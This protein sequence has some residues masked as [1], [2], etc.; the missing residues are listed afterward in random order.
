MYIIY[1]Y[2]SALTSHRYLTRAP[3]AW[4]RS[5]IGTEGFIITS[6]FNGFVGGFTYHSSIYPPLPVVWFWVHQ[7]ALTCKLALFAYD[8]AVSMYIHCLYIRTYDSIRISYTIGCIDVCGVWYNRPYDTMP[9]PLDSIFYQIRG[10]S[11]PYCCWGSVLCVYKPKPK[12]K[13][14]CC[15]YL[16]VCTRTASIAE[17]LEGGDVNKGGMKVIASTS[18][19]TTG[20]T[21]A[22]CMPSRIP[23]QM[24]GA[25]YCP[26]LA[27]FLACWY[28]L[29]WD[30]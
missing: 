2:I 14:Y 5:L 18:S 27:F 24:R 7:E 11:V 29:V 23:R 26:A 1:I 3:T 28:S 20:Q 17:N 4:L 16:L 8:V 22:T 13:I 9:H 19:S 30:R 10:C 25:T 6:V 12:T 21:S 15:S